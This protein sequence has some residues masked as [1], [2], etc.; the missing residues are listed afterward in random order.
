MVTADVFRDALRDFPAGVTIV[1][2]ADATATPLG[3]TVSAFTSLSIDPPLI[4]V[5]LKSDSRSV[6]AIRERKAFCVQ[7]LDRSQVQLA[8]RFAAD[9]ANKF[10]GESFS[11]NDGGVP[12]LGSCRL[13][14]ECDLESDYAGGDHVILVGLVAAAKRLSDFEPPVYARRSFSPSAVWS[15]SP[16]N[17]E[18]IAHCGR[19]RRRPEEVTRRARLGFNIC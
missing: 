9:Q 6:A 7:F 18:S 19:D 1:T 14:L 2:M 15:R 5:C 12:C 4:L 17:D 3:A 16:W 13:R 8:R 10:N 11:V